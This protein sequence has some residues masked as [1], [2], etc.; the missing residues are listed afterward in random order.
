MAF[1]QKHTP[2]GKN[3]DD[4]GRSGVAEKM[5]GPQAEKY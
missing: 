5:P 1:S 2:E 4:D 3:T